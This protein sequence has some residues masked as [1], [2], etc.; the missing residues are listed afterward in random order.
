MKKA[1]KHIS[2]VSE[3]KDV[4]PLETKQPTKKHMLRRSLFIILPLLTLV[5]VLGGTLL[6][7]S[8]HKSP[9]AHADST[10]FVIRNEGSGLCLNADPNQTVGAHPYMFTCNGGDPNQL[11]HF[12]GN[13]YQN[14]YVVDQYN[15]EL[16]YATTRFG[17]IESVSS[18][19]AGHPL[20]LDHDNQKQNVGF[21]PYLYGCYGGEGQAWNDSGFYFGFELIDNQEVVHYY[22]DNNNVVLSPANKTDFG[23]GSNSSSNSFDGGVNG[24]GSNPYLYTPDSGNPNQHWDIQY[25]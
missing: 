17:S 2:H 22:T 13:G 18:D 4:S 21:Q 5:I 7:S 25:V 12:S 9:K 6:N 14:T 19:N 1:E 16:V 24:V 3:T 11:W 10:T 23:N 20:C 15:G 8:L